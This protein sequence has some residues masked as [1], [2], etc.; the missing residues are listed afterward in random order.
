[1]TIWNYC[2]SIKSELFVQQKQIYDDIISLNNLYVIT[3]AAP[4]KVYDSSLEFE[5]IMIIPSRLFKYTGAYELCVRQYDRVCTC[6]WDW[7]DQN[8]DTLLPLPVRFLA[9]QIYNLERGFLQV[10]VLYH[11][12][13]GIG[14]RSPQ[15]FCS[16][17]PGRWNS[18]DPLLVKF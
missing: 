9:R 15:V 10:L 14:I 12:K 18:N 13:L 8:S 4:L 3:S 1:M 5:W 2:F 7:V 16:L 17:D 11:E 6:I